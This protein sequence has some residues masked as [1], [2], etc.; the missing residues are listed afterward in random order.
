M[1]TDNEKCDKIISKI[2]NAVDEIVEKDLL[3]EVKNKRKIAMA[4]SF[5]EFIK[6]DAEIDVRVNDNDVIYTVKLK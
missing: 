3:K 6:E 1:S 4:S 5:L 2:C